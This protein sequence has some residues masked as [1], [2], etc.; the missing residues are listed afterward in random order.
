MHLRYFPNDFRSKT[1]T[2]EINFVFNTIVLT[3]ELGCDV[4]NYAQSNEQRL[5]PHSHPLQ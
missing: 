2:P 4:G 1:L 5:Y 3:Y